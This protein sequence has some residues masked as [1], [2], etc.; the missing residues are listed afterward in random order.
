MAGG[1]PPRESTGAG[2]IGDD[3]SDTE[4]IATHGKTHDKTHDK[5]HGKTH[6]KAS[7][8]RLRAVEARERLEGRRPTSAAVDTL[9]RTI[10]LDRDAG[11]ALLAGAI[12]FRFFLLLVTFAFLV[13]IGQGIGAH[14]AGA[15]PRDVARHAGIT[16]LAAVAIKSGADASDAARWVTFVLATVAVVLGSRNLVRVLA[17]SYARI[18]NVPYRRPRHGALAGIA[19]VGLAAVV[20]VLIRLVAAVRGLSFFGWIAALV[21]FV[22]VPATMWL[23][24]SAKV[25]PA[26]PGVTWRRLLPGAVLFGVGVEALHLATVLWVAPSIETKSAAYGAIGAALTLLVWAYLLGRLITSA[27]MVNVVALKR[28]TKPHA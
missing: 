15:Q 11:G 6:D 18:W 21:L 7:S 20:L 2:P 14:V 9:F 8:M 26:R 5:A 16:G 4:R 28:D 23:V 12:A 1:R 24:G 25:F 3:R 17:V 27:E 22:A 19:V 10:Q 13:V